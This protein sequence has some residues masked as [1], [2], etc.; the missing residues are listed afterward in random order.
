ML[1]N[2]YVPKGQFRQKSILAICYAISSISG[3]EPGAGWAVVRAHLSLGVRVSV[4][5]TRECA[6]ELDKQTD[7]YVN[8]LE[9]ISMNYGK[10]ATKLLQRTPVQ[11]K[12]VYW[13]ICVRLKLRHKDFS[14][15]DAVHHITY[16]GDWNPTLIHFLPRNVITLWGPVGG[17]QKVPKSFSKHF[18][19]KDRIKNWSH[20][21][22]G[23]FAR[24]LLRLR[25]RRTRSVVLAAN[26]ATKKCYEK[27]TKVIVCQNVSFPPVSITQE[28][29]YK[30]DSNFYFGAGRLLY[31][32][33]WETPIRA[34]SH[35]ENEQLLIAGEGPHLKKLEQL[36]LDLDLQ[37]RVT[38]LGKI[39]RQDVL[40]LMTRSKGFVFPSL[41][42]SASWALGEAIHL[43]VPVIAFDLPGNRC[44][45]ESGDVKLVPLLKNPQLEFANAMMNIGEA[46][47]IVA[48]S[49]C[50][51]LLSE[52]L[53]TR[54][55]P[56]IFHEFE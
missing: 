42:D 47:K 17:A 46:K 33:N 7:Y 30:S 21:Y 50:E 15:F 5:T 9:I 51:C 36:I 22:F 16:S 37:A 52:T 12:Y 56:N 53:E 18:E 4:I 20:S 48:G 54:V 34:M 32:K 10:I 28:L 3:S 40:R 13:N 1:H 35:I 26:S 45:S 25:I 23:D 38:L 43:G 6:D 14:K 27:V 29:G 39:D 41:R 24:L 8:N 31:F 2:C 49:K 55:Y 19:I 11:I 44:L